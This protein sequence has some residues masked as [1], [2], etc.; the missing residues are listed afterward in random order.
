M[1]KILSWLSLNLASVLGI[2]Q[3]VI[4]VIKEIATA[5]VNILFPL[6]PSAKFQKVVLLVR[7]IANKADE[8][9]QKIKSFFLSAVN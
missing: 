9:I 1:K 8:V 4:K 3:G 7:N 6:I 5:I 2:A